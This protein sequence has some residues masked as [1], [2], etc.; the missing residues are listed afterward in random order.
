MTATI[1][2]TMPT[3]GPA[4]SGRKPIDR[5]ELS[6]RLLGSAAKKSYD[7]AV[8]IDWAAPIPEGLY[9]LSPEWS[10]LYGT[11]LWDSLSKDQR[12]TLS[13]LPPRSR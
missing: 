12:I 6:T 3:T 5:Q 11:P 9:G 2:S 10:T 8:D 7:P 4:Q 13:C 1:P